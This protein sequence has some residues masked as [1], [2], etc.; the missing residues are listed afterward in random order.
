MI[1]YKMRGGGM[2]CITG[3]VDCKGTPRLGTAVDTLA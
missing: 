2:Y 3:V 1:L